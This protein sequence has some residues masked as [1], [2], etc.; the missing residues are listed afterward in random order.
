MMRLLRIIVILWGCLFFTPH[1]VAAQT[2]EHNYNLPFGSNPYAPSR[3]KAGF[4]GFLKPSDFPSARY[5]SK[6]HEQVHTQWRESAHANSFRAPF[7]L[8]NVQMLIDQKGIE[9]TR[10]CEA[11]HNPV[12]LF[13]GALTKDSTIQR[14]FDEEGVTCS[15]CHSI[16]KIDTN[17]GIGS[18]ELGRPAIMLNADGSPRTDVPSYDEI[19]ENPG[20]HKRAVMRDFLT[21]PEFCSVCHKAALPPEL[22]GYK[23]L[24]AFSVYD[25]WQQSSWSKQSALP[26]YQKDKVSTCQNCHMPLAP[27]EN[28]YGAKDGKISSHRFPGANTAIPEYYSYPD[29]IE[30]VRKLMSNSVGLDFVAVTRKHKGKTLQSILIDGGPLRITPGDEITVDLVIQNRG[31]GHSL[32]P[33]QRDFYESWVEFTAKD[34]RGKLLLQSGALN[35]KGFLDPDAH[36]YTNR[37]IDSSGSGL[38]LH[39]VWN[40]RLKAYDNT[41]MPGRSDLVRYRF[42]MPAHF[43]G[44]VTLSAAVRYRRFRQRYTDFILDTHASYPVLEL[45][46]TKLLLRTGYQQYQSPTES[47]QTLLRW[48][49]YG[50]ALLGQQQWWRATDAFSHTTA[51]DPAYVDGYVNAAIAEYSKWIEARKENPDGPGVFSLDNANA[52]G[53]KF[54]PAMELLNKALA[55]SPAYPRALFYQ[56]VILRLQNR[57][58]E[59]AANLAEVAKKYPAMR[60]GHQELGYVLYLKKDY[61]KASS[62]FEAVKSINPDDVTACYYLSL[63]YA[64]LGK[65]HEA[66]ENSKLYSER[67]DDP[68]NY[69]LNLE[70]VKTHPDEALELTPYHVH[71][72]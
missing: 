33:E 65:S 50:I 13:T 26:F 1:D 60:Q 64:N 55:L 68:N 59:A 30:A 28:P 34:G 51:I 35:D 57:L 4:S 24:R 72:K 71:D 58:D 47:K 5:C 20:L 16:T 8:K 69:A 9:Y 40:T 41:I 42:R 37:L 6:C 48:N 38:V 36:S 56:G 25:E 61:Q 63:I 22:D 11:C 44:T 54:V 27:A 3:A 21:T 52:P 12:A 46:S 62:E 10:H 32:V 2:A 70:F 39:Q 23:W 53:E 66:Q 19:L 14:P 49:N 67:R 15:V 17:V 45:G 43:F 7:Y 29:Q 31:I 18:Y